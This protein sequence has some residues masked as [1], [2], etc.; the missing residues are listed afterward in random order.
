VDKNLWSNV[1]HLT[2][3]DEVKF[4]MDL[5]KI[6]IGRAT[7]CSDTISP[8]VAMPCCSR[9]SLAGST[10]AQ[11]VEWILTDKLDVRF[12]FRCTIHLEPDTAR[13]LINARRLQAVVL[14]RED[15]EGSHNR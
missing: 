2:L 3:R 13:S 6:T 7:R 14:S 11:I 8:P 1:D 4:V 12:N 15:D 10:P 5:A 9:R